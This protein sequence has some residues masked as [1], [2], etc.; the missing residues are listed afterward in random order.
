M[1]TKTSLRGLI[2]QAKQ[3]YY[4]DDFD[5]MTTFIDKAWAAALESG[6]DT[7]CAET[8]H[9]ASDLFKRS[10]QLE[11][12]LEMAFLAVKY[13]RETGQVNEVWAAY[14][15]FLA[16]LLGEMDRASEG[17]DYAVEA[18]KASIS[19]L[20]KDHY[21]TRIKLGLLYTLDAQV[22]QEKSQK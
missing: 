19:N 6:C 22:E 16:K 14:N 18:V 8:A 10:G 13:K 20:G 11:R 4:S 3:G 7:T 2:I 9:C 17:I 15:A 21:E 5:R 12:A 1:H